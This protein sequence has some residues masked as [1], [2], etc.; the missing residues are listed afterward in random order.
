MRKMTRILVLVAFSAS[1]LGAAGCKSDE[2]KFCDH[3]RKVY[4]DK[5]D[6]CETD[7]LAEIKK[8]CT[9][10]EAVFA[11]ALKVEDKKAVKKCFREI[12]EEKKKEK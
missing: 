1:I 7:A 4:G 10:P 3:M 9:N 12:C 5:M 6:D 2:D 11:C 8:D